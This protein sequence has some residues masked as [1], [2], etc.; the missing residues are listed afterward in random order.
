MMLTHSTSAS[1]LAKFEDRLA[2]KIEPLKNIPATWYLDSL[3]LATD[4]I[5]QLILN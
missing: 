4:Q 2:T 1:T 5:Q 3:L